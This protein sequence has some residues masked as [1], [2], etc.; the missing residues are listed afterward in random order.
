MTRVKLTVC[1]RCGHT[2]KE[3]DF[4][5]MDVQIYDQGGSGN[6]EDAFTLCDPCVAKL[7]EW[8]SRKKSPNRGNGGHARAAKL[9]PEQRSEI[10][11]GAANVRWQND[12]PP[13]QESKP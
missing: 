6:S 4:E 8:I 9:T 11:R 7:R 1:N 12:S 5:G 13:T 10:A 2:D 3:N